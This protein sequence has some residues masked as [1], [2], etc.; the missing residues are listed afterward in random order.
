MVFRAS[1]CVINTLSNAVEQALGWVATKRGLGMLPMVAL[2]SPA[3]WSTPQCEY[4][5]HVEDGS[6]SGSKGQSNSSSTLFEEM[7][8]GTRRSWLL[9]YRGLQRGKK[10][11][12]P[13]SHTRPHLKKTLPAS[14]QN[15]NPN[16]TPPR[17]L[18]TFLFPVK[19]LPRRKPPRWINNAAASK[20]HRRNG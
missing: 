9:E 17:L 2:F 14:A 12:K 1:L 8:L 4:G 3:C 19:C 10:N 18:G 11:K 5:S 6:N 16:S 7:L 15:C 20:R 13:K